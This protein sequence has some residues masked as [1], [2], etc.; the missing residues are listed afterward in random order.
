MASGK[1]EIS[2]LGRIR[3]VKTGLVLSHMHIG[4]GK[5]FGVRIRVLWREEIVPRKM[6][7]HR[8]VA[9]AFIPNPDNKPQVNHKDG[10]KWNN[11][12]ENLEWVTNKE[13]SFH[14][15]YVLGKIPTAT[16]YIY[17]N[18]YTI[19]TKKIVNIE[20]GKVY[21][22]VQELATILGRAHKN[23]RKKL[24]GQRKN[25]TPY[26]YEGSFHIAVVHRKFIPKSERV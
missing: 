23:L 21:E 8:L 11:K 20:N 1:Y 6:F 10:D 2:S 22:S 14:A 12:V 15:Q 17:K 25:N 16:P 4:K 18:G 19:K 3:N 13:N 7:I 24:N 5:Y 9:L 26:R